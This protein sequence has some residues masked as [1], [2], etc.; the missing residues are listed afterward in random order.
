M[1]TLFVELVYHF[2]SYQESFGFLQIKKRNP[3]G[4]LLF[5]YEIEN[6]FGKNLSCCFVDNA[7][8]L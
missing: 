8:G 6:A 4:F 3:F 5:L 1:N 7:L 2:L